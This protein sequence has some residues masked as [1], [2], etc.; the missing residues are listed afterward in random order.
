MLLLGTVHCQIVSTRTPKPTSSSSSGK[1][2]RRLRKAAHLDVHREGDG[3]STTDNTREG[4]PHCHGAATGSPY[5]LG[6]AL[7][8]DFWHDIC[9]ARCVFFPPVRLLKNPISLW[10]SCNIPWI[11]P[12]L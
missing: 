5:S 10:Y 3:S 2:R 4:G 8:R 7:F 6:I 12:G 11:P 1:R 9:K